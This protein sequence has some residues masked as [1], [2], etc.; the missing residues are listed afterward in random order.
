MYYELLRSF[1]EMII[2]LTR[3][4]GWLI[5]NY[6]VRWQPFKK[7]HKLKI[8]VSYLHKIPLL[9]VILQ[10]GCMHLIFYS[11]FSSEL[12]SVYIPLKLMECHSCLMWYY[13][14]IRWYTFLVACI[15]N[16]FV[17]SKNVFVRF[18]NAV[19]W[20]QNSFVMLWK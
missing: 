2:F 3:L 8:H 17:W 4:G 20:F 1:N 5:E 11:H 6:Y 15:Q 13:H 7:I 16:A 12:L 10:R 19:A 9:A 18:R 14:I